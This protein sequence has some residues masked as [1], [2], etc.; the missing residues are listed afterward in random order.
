MRARSALTVL[1]MASSLFI[2]TWARRDTGLQYLT[3]SGIFKP[4][5]GT[6]T[7][8]DRQ[9]ELARKSSELTSAHNMLEGKFASENG[10]HGL[11]SKLGLDIAGKGGSEMGDSKG[12]LQGLMPLIQSGMAKSPGEILSAEAVQKL[13]FVSQPKVSVDS[14]GC[15]EYTIED[16]IPVQVNQDTPNEPDHSVYDYAS[17]LLQLYGV[18]V[19]DSFFGQT[20][21]SEVASGAKLLHKSGL[22]SALDNGV[23]GNAWYHGVEEDWLDH[24]HPH[25]HSILDHRIDM[26]VIRQRL[27]NRWPEHL[28]THGVGA[29]TVG[30]ASVA[31]YMTEMPPLVH[32]GCPENSTPGGLYHVR[33]HCDRI[34]EKPSIH[35][36]GE[37]SSIEIIYFAGE[38]SSCSSEK[39]GG[40]LTLLFSLL[41][42]GAHS[43]LQV[44]EGCLMEN[45]TIHVNVPLIPDRL[46]MLLSE[47]ISYN[48]S[49]PINGCNLPH[50]ATV[51]K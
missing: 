25:V 26:E 41:D 13:K 4:P 50:L 18:A 43:E 19:I 33:S 2:T 40:N 1:I 9:D 6:Q 39:D 34:S 31:R 49:T 5:G 7:I 42:E 23:T 35:S 45:R 11:L 27:N 10:L 46:V 28:H 22:L 21:A 36:T 48:I 38:N 37:H 29:T 47:R 51:I 15:T 44:P 30:L 20:V 17:A 24:D 16:M 32:H 3:D 12:I 14:R 8:E